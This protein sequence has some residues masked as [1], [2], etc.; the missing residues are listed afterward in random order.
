MIALLLP[1]SSE[2]VRQL[3]V[4]RGNRGE[5]VDGTTS[6]AAGGLPDY[7]F[8]STDERDG[9]RRQLKSPQGFT[10]DLPPTH[11]PQSEARKASEASQRASSSSMSPF[12][13]S[14]LDGY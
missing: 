8:S 14:A 6:G 5:G 2:R 4:P 10:I 11:L 12:S 1:L 7:Y 13:T 9:A 3:F